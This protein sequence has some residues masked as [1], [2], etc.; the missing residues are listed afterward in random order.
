MRTASKLGSTQELQDKFHFFDPES[1]CHRQVPLGYCGHFR[2]R[3]M[4][5][6]LPCLRTSETIIASCQKHSIPKVGLI[7]L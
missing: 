5:Y 4:N 3:Q 6:P 7:T 2:N 1:S